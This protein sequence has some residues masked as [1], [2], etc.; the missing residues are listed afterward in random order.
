MFR[1]SANFLFDSLREKGLK[2]DTCLQI[3]IDSSVEEKF[4]ILQASIVFDDI[5]YPIY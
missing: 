3:N 1:N 5:N 2:D 4:L